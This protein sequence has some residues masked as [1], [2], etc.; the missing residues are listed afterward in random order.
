MSLHPLQIRHSL[1]FR[2]VP[3]WIFRMIW[4]TFI[5][6]RTTPFTE[7]NTRS[8]QTQRE[9]TLVA[10]VSSCFLSE[11]VD[12]TKYGVIYGGV[13]KN[14]GSAG[15]VIVIAR[16]D[17]ITDDVT[18]WHQPCSSGRHRQTKTACTTHRHAT[19]FISAVKSLS[20]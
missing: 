18:S 2:I 16:E 9:R 11:P 7:P 3:I 5:S 6:V 14:I 8:F 1:I 13:Q 10:D 15:V 17:L 19:A 20:G 12:V 4:I